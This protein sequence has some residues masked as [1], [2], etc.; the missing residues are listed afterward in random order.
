MNWIEDQILRFLQR[1][2]KH[3]GTMVAVDILEGCGGDLYVPY[4]NRC[5]AI[6][7]EREAVPTPQRKWPPLQASWRLPDPNLWRGK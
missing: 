6:R 5:G 4:C 3:P 2:C 7:P 1:R